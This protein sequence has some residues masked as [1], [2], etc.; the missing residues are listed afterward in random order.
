MDKVMSKKYAMIQI[1]A[2]VHQVL[3]EFCKER[4]YK[5]NGLVETL[6]KDKVT[7]I[8]QPPKN[9]LPTSKV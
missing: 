5:I 3:K 4:G 6:I 2:E 7:S 1:D 9:I 8:K